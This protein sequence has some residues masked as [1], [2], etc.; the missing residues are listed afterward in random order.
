MFLVGTRYLSHWLGQDAGLDAVSAQ[1]DGSPIDRAVFAALIA[2][3][4]VVLMM[5]GKA[6]LSALGRNK[7][8]LLF[9]LFGLFS[10]LWSEYPLISLKRW[11]K[12]SGN[13]VMALVL[14]TEADPKAAVGL[15]LRYLA[16]LTLPLS[17]VFIKYFPALGR[18]IHH[19]QQL[20]NGVA[21]HKNTLGQLCLLSG[22]YFFWSYL[23]ERKEWATASRRLFLFFFMATTAWLLFMADSATSQGALGVA[24]ILLVLSRLPVISVK[25]GRLL[26]VTVVLA[27]GFIGLQLFADITS[28]VVSGLGRDPSLTTRVPMWAELSR[29]PINV[30]IGSGYETFWLTSFGLEMQDQWGVSQAH[31]G[32]LELYLNLGLVGLVLTLAAM[33][34]G[35]ARTCRSNAEDQGLQS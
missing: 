1:L 15:V 16:V 11:F 17:V 33:L 24:L 19:G 9:F 31:N 30:A 8:L 7:L 12:A 28:A 5:R 22:I 2:A 14:L 3:G 32:Y 29:A 34:A 35:L 6:T 4:I 20:Y 27:F 26:A 18:S 23:Y 21:L 10:V 13:L 25:P